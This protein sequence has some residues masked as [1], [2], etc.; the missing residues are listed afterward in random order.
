[1]QCECD[2]LVD[3]QAPPAL[4]RVGDGLVAE[5]AAN[6]DKR[7]LVQLR[8]PRE[9][10]GAR[11]LIQNL[12]AR[13][14]LRCRIGSSCDREHAGETREVLADAETVVVARVRRELVER[15]RSNPAVAQRP[16]GPSVASSM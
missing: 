12:Q 4:E 16:R 13:E 15:Q 9:H 11:L 7:R 10:A 5:P 8:H 6:Q 1:M 2:G 3:R 14:K